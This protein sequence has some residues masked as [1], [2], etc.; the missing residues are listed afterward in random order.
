MKITAA[1]MFSQFLNSFLSRNSL[2]TPLSYMSTKDQD[3]AR[4]GHTTVDTQKVCKERMDEFSNLAKEAKFLKVPRS[5][6]FTA[7]DPKTPIG[8]NLL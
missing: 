4:G 8:G 3:Q 2:E 7:Y 1:K 5:N 6:R